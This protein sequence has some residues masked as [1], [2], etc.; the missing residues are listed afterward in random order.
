MSRGRRRIGGTAV[1]ALLFV[2]YALIQRCSQRSVNPIT[3]K[4]EYVSMSAEQEIEMGLASRDGLAQQ[5]GG[6]YPD[7]AVQ[8]QIDNVG[9]AL[10]ANSD[11]KKSPYVFEFHVLNDPQTVNAFALPG[12]QIFITTALL[13]QLETE[14]QV[15]GVLGHEI[16]HVIER[17]SAE[18][19]SES[20]FFSNLGNAASILLGGGGGSSQVIGQVINTS[21][22]AN[23]RGDEL[24]SD[25]LG[26]KYMIQSGYDPSEMIVVMDV[27]KKA[28]GGSS[29]PEFLSSHPD[30]ENRKENIIA[31][32]NKYKGLGSVSG[33]Y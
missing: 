19:I 6:L 13:S 1:I 12:G 25:D 14:D 31:S 32:I 3:G 21:L 22:K 10:V 7:N 9:N 28:S 30:P 18:R 11:A 23:G 20:Q 26:V 27:L 5:F 17:H 29:Q 4:V 8:Q 2:G 24:E 33:S 15:A 16:G